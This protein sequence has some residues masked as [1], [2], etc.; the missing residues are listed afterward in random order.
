MEGIGSN[1]RPRHNHTDVG[2]GEIQIREGRVHIA[3]IMDG[4]R[5]IAVVGLLQ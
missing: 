2:R 3:E 1:N 4:E 5:W